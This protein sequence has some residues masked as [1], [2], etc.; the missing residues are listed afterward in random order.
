MIDLPK[1]ACTQWP[2][3]HFK[4]HAVLAACYQANDGHANLVQGEVFVGE[5][6]IE[7]LV[8]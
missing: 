6:E 4:V 8:V 5:Y 3:G 1:M 2:H 7:Q